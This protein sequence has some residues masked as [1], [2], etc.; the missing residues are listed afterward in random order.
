[1]NNWRCR[2]AACITALSV[3]LAAGAASEQTLAADDTFNP[4][5]FDLE[6]S[7]GEG[8]H[9]R[10]VAPLTNPIF[11]ETPHI[12]T[13]ARAFYFYHALPNDFVTGGGDV[14]L[15]ALQLRVA[16]TDR[17]GFIA[18]KDG[19]ADFD[20]DEVLPD[21]SGFA[22][23]AL[24]FKYALIS[25]PE[26]E[27]IL[28]AGLRYEIPINDLETG[29]I[30]LQG[31]GDGFLNPFLTG[32]TVY[33]D[34]GLQASVGANVALDAD[35]D[36]SILHY[37]LHGD[38]ELFEGFFPLVELNGFTAIDNGKRTTGALADLDG[39]DVLNFGSEDRDTTV[40]AGGGFRYRFD[41][42]IQ[43][44]LGAETPITDKDDTIFDYRVY[45]DLVLSM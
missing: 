3:L 32:S 25:R 6:G 24:G 31:D 45:V 33:G 39:V 9:S 27:T 17:L 14:N 36:T 21:E 5:G 29:G 41:D 4:F 28:T 37:S 8:K 23:V 18:T 20:F 1:M 26:D 44:G 2:G 10:Y 11:N 19:Y 15:A 30:E 16:I 35:E 22:N 7:L 43:L 13:E 12:T 34:F 40:T 38:Y 42:N